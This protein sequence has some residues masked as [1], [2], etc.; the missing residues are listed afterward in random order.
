MVSS[1]IESLFS[2]DMG[3]EGWSNVN[4]HVVLNP[5]AH[6]QAIATS[7]TYIHQQPPPT[8]GLQTVGQS[9]YV[10]TV[11]LMPT[12][13]TQTQVVGNFIQP[14]LYSEFQKPHSN[15]IQANVVINGVTTTMDLNVIEKY[16]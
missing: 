7:A 6:H 5:S 10:T 3:N 13:Q 11:D 16:E 8:S 2:T 15:P 12:H 9:N 1:F 14:Q 4:N